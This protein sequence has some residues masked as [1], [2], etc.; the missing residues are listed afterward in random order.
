M[1][2]VIRMKDEWQVADVG[3][4]QDIVE[5]QSPWVEYI[6]EHLP[7]IGATVYSHQRD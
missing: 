1:G 5:E 2:D 7:E 6:Y 3:F 4:A